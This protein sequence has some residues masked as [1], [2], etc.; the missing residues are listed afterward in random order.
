MSTDDKNS[1]SASFIRPRLMTLITLW[2]I[3]LFSCTPR[4]GQNL[5]SDQTDLPPTH[6]MQR[7][8]ADNISIETQEN[9]RDTL[10]ENM[11]KPYKQKLEKEMNEVIAT[12]AT[13]LY[14]SKPESP[15]GNWLADELLQYLSD[16]GND[17]DLTLL[18]YGGIRLGSLPEGDLTVGKIYELLPFENQMVIMELDPEQV[19]TLFEHM[20]ASGGWPIS[21]DWEI[22]YN[23]SG[24][25]SILYKGKPV[26]DYATIKVALPD[27][28]ANGG[29]DTSFLVGI[30]RVSTQILLRDAIIDALI[31]AD[32]PEIKAAIENRIKKNE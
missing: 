7:V 2:T 18:N 8:Q 28:V 13:K 26:R 1:S 27:Y 21:K 12:V 11:V 6:V 15:L 30:P 31:A 10:V 25:T 22:L 14:K 16:H 32:N 23:D 4:T 20:T 9:K 17:I 19:T 29:S 24:V 3:A 5:S